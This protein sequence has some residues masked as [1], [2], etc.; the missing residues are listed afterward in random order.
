MS[1]KEARMRKSRNV[2]R[3]LVSSGVKMNFKKASPFT[4]EQAERH[5]RKGFAGLGRGRG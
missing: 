2:I 4:Q 3:G 5:R 1:K